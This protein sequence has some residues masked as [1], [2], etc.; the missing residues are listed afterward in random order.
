MQRGGRIDGKG[1]YQINDA[2]K[3]GGILYR[4]GTG[5]IPRRA[6]FSVD[7]P[8][9]LCWLYFGKS[10]ERMVERCEELRRSPDLGFLQKMTMSA[11]I[12]DLNPPYVLL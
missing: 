1:G 10:F 6:D 4:A 2:V 7:L 3:A 12:E 9:M 8:A 5:K 11:T